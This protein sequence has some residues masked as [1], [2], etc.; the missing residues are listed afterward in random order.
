M[1]ALSSRQ[2]CDITDARHVPF[3]LGA[4]EKSRFM[5]NR[6]T[7]YI[8]EWYD[9]LPKAVAGQFRRTGNQYFL[10][11]MLLMMLGTYT[12]VFQSPLEPVTVY[13]PLSIVIMVSLVQEGYADLKRHRDDEEVNNKE[14]QRING[15]TLPWQDI[16]VG[17]ILK[18]R[19][20]EEVPADMVILQTSDAADGICYCETKAIDGETNLKRRSK[21]ADATWTEAAEA[22]SYGVEC[23]PVGTREQASIYSFNGGIVQPDGSKVPVAP[24]NVLLRGSVLRNTQ[25]V[26]GVVVYT[27][28]E[29]KLAKNAM[30]TPQKISQ[31]D[32]L[33]NSAILFVLTG[34]VFFC[35]VSTIL[36]LQWEEDHFGNAPYL[37]YWKDGH[38]PEAYRNTTVFPQYESM[39]WESTTEPFHA[40]L[41]TFIVLYYNVITISLY[42][43]IEIVTRFMMIY[44]ETDLHMYH[45]PIDMPA[46]A[47][48]TNV[49]DLGQ[50]EYIFSDKTGTLTQNVMKFKCCSVDGRVFGTKMKSVVAEVDDED[51]V[52]EPLSTLTYN[53]FS[54]HSPGLRPFVEIL[55][56]CHS[57]VVEREKGE[58]VYQAESPDEGALVSAAAKIGYSLQDRDARGMTVSVGKGTA[59]AVAFQ[60]LAINEF[61]A[62]RK[63]MSVLIKYPDGK[64]RLLVKGADSS[65]VRA[66]KNADSEVVRNLHGHLEHFAKQGLRTL[67][68][69]YRDFEKDELDA[70]LAKYNAAKTAVQNRDEKVMAVAEEAESGLEIIGATAIEDKL[71]DGVPDTITTVLEAG[72]KFWVLTGDKRETAI[73]I[74][75]SCGLIQPSMT[76]VSL[77]G[78]DEGY[79]HAQLSSLFAA[80][81]G[82][83]KVK[84]AGCGTDSAVNAAIQ[85][86]V[87]QHSAAAGAAS[88]GDPE[89][90][91]EE[92]ERLLAVGAPVAFVMEGTALEHVMPHEH[93]KA[94]LFSIAARCNAVMACRATPA[95]KALLVETVHTYVIPKPVTL[96]IGDGANDVGMIQKAQVGIGI[97]GLEGQQAVNASDFAIAQFR[98]LKR[99]LLVH[100]RWNY[101]RMAVVV[102]YSFYKNFVM[103]V[104]LFF[105]G[106]SAGWSGTPLYDQWL[107]G[108][109]N[110]FTTLPVIAIGIFEKDVPAE[111]ALSHPKMYNTGRLNMDM[112]SRKILSWVVTALVHGLIIYG[113]PFLQFGGNTDDGLGQSYTI[114]GTTIFISLVTSMNIKVL[115]ET[116]TV[117]FFTKET[118]SICSRVGRAMWCSKFSG[119]H[120][121]LWCLSMLMLYLMYICYSTYDIAYKMSEMRF[122]QI[123]VAVLDRLATWL[124]MLIIPVVCVIA[125]SLPWCFQF[126]FCPTPLMVTVE[127]AR[128]SGGKGGVKSADATA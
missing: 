24:S 41:L 124:Y 18:L 48:S 119:W 78:G 43:T 5:S 59:S 9:F 12:D 67:V 38:T 88:S 4:A 62:T 33:V 82:T 107:Y 40:G 80:F 11:M 102:M 60:E 23:D 50:I 20:R 42:V 72:I 57:V 68:L 3:P 1:G 125:D 84:T 35:I 98:F 127:E 63:R 31:I 83:G 16:Q 46:K 110:F 73:E 96:A 25:W 47:R 39:E 86:M 81:V 58:I 44:V 8:Y 13:G 115:E 114:Y 106:A 122:Y 6:Y 111:Y 103:V 85:D 105:F 36:K 120:I 61:D 95:Q 10:L 30:K 21:P 101:R 126:L 56:L 71:Q 34:D 65:M 32:K 92:I 27:G 54:D 109:Y 64:A 117:T 79:V 55:A 15:A 118:L 123:G 116:R 89:A 14:A 93:M 69:G 121:F 7:T 53:L 75:K 28:F 66:A 104:T 113:V 112:D 76:L 19:N 45:A 77:R 100:G 17:M 128:L 29:T 99:L 51:L 70:W 90:P 22:G 37:G 87:A 91:G 97:A 108:G 49:T 94:M 52:F 74:G 2:E 26:H